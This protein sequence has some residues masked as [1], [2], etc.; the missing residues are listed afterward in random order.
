[1][2]K[3]GM[4]L[5]LVLALT[6]ALDRKIVHGCLRQP[7]L[8][9][10]E[11]FKN[12]TRQVETIEVE[13]KQLKENLSE[14]LANRLKSTTFKLWKEQFDMLRQNVRV[15]E[16]KQ[17]E[18]DKDAQSTSE[19]IN[20]MQIIINRLVKDISFDIRTDS[21]KQ[22]LKEIQEKTDN[23]ENRLQIAKEEMN[24]LNETIKIKLQA[25]T[26]ALQ[27]LENT[28]EKN[29][30]EFQQS[31]N[32]LSTVVYSDLEI[33][34]SEINR[35]IEAVKE[36]NFATDKRLSDLHEVM[37]R[38]LLNTLNKGAVGTAFIAVVMFLFILAFW[39]H[40]IQQ[41]IEKM[42]KRQ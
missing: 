25:Y 23:Q 8:D 19:Q 11:A 22:L 17:G 10:V 15:V 32:K 33:K 12:L 2:T 27:E 13:Q 31:L 40:G 26:N 35:N 3:S 38:V 30:K 6:A 42:S 14:C 24:F 20:E 21:G 37:D 5:I 36:A 41:K 9:K 18:V 34:S 39:M 1:M 7:A 4:Y 29:L 16:I 28:S